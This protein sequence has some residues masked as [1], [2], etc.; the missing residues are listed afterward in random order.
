[1]DTLTRDQWERQ[2]DHFAY[3][4]CA[5]RSPDHTFRLHITRPDWETERKAQFPDMP[6]LNMEVHLRHYQSFWARLRRA[7]RF[8]LGYGPNMTDWDSAMLNPNEAMKFS[9]AC[10]QFVSEYNVWVKRLHEAGH[11][12][13]SGIEPSPASPPACC[14]ASIRAE[15]NPLRD[16]RVV[17]QEFETGHWTAQGLEIDYGGEGTSYEDVRSRFERGLLGT[18]VEHMKL[19]GN[20]NK[21]IESAP[22]DVWRDYREKTMT[23]HSTLYYKYM[24]NVVLDAGG[25]AFP[26]EQIKFPFDR[27]VYIVTSEAK[28]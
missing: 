1:M 22:D 21:M 27:I 26:L 28:S 17:I 3:I 5:C 20:V 19:F 9:D 4:T 23:H 2:N 25:L 16:L 10:L 24:Q 8:V 13:T 6:E 18:A 11:T 14:V 7:V 12:H 15:Y